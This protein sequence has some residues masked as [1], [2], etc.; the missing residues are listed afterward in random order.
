MSRLVEDLLELSRLEAPDAA[1]YKKPTHVAVEIEEAA[2]AFVPRAEARNVELS[3]LVS[4][5]LPRVALDRD[6]FRQ[7]VSN[8]VDN[9]VK[10]S[11]PGDRVTVSC[12]PDGDAVVLEVADTGPGVAAEDLPHLTTRLYRAGTNASGA[13]GAGLGLAVVDRIVRLHDGSLELES[14]AGGGFVARVRLPAGAPP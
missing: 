9:A 6:R 1:L 5:A 2:A 10:F 3:L 13:E 14:A 4:S 11:R 8:L 12:Q 7:V